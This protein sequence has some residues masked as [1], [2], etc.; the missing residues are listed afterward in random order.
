MA[1]TG[2][3][4]H[5]L[6]VCVASGGGFV[7]HFLD[8]LERVLNME[9]NFTRPIF[10]HEFWVKYYT[11]LLLPMCMEESDFDYDVAVDLA[12]HKAQ[13]LAAKWTKDDFKS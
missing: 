4:H 8:T 2:N 11:G 12:M 1:P 6:A 13:E 3:A 7:L 10:D 5:N 9:I